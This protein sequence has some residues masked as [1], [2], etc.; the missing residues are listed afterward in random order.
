[1][2]LRTR[3][4]MLFGAAMLTAMFTHVASAENAEEAVWHNKIPAVLSEP[5][6]DIDK[7]P[8]LLH[9][10]ADNAGTK[11]HYVT[12]GSDKKPLMVFV[13]GFPDFWYSWRNQI[14][15]FSE[16]YQ[17]VAL[18]LRGYNLSGRPE[19]V[20]PYKTPILLDDIRAVINAESNGRKAILIGHDWGAALSWLFTGQ[21][22]DLIERLVVLSVPHP[23]AITKELLP[24]NHPVAQS[25]ASAYATRFFARG[26]GDNLTAEELAYWIVDPQIK[27]RYIE[28]F[29]RSSISSMMSY[30]KANYTFSQFALNLFDPTMKKI[31]GAVIRCPVLHVHGIEETHALLSTLDLEKSWIENPDNLTVKIV[32]GVGHFIQQ[33]VPD[34]LNQTISSWLKDSGN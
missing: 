9:R 1:M 29:K 24:W 5:A 16:N 27:S 6:V 25:R 3:S 34:Y 11:I 14:K 20:E 33:E 23:G 4:M 2:A 12:M 10:Y 17:V 8:N 31:Y 26:K 19:G 32:P 15:A 18:D 13:H 28:A 7:D 30:Y 22:P 21:N